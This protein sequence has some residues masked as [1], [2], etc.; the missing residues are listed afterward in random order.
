MQHVLSV[1]GLRVAGILLSGAI[2][3]GCANMRASCD[4]RQNPDGGRGLLIICE[5]NPIGME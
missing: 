2:L 3:S 1:R 5:E 4:F